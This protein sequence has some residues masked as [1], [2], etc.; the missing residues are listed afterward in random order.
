M[1]NPN[2]VYV[3]YGRLAFDP[4]YTPANG[5]KPQY[6]KFRIA[7]NRSRGSDADFYDCVAFRQK[8]DIIREY[9]KK[10]KEIRIVATPQVDK[11]TD[12][13]G[14]KRERVSLIVEEFGFCGS[15]SDSTGNGSNPL[16]WASGSGADSFEQV[17][18]DVPF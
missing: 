2:S 1:I 8:A 14:N 15:K 7:I 3:G 17:E 11:Y 5:D 18:E 16:A 4:E 6:V 9:F 12:K 10:G 13:N